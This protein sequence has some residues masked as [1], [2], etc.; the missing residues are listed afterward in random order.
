MQLLLEYLPIVAFFV[1]YKF[2]GGIYTATA[3]LMIS[4]PLLLAVLWLRAKKL[5]A[6]FAVSTVLVLAFGAA[7]L[8]LRDP[9]FIQW[10]PSIFMWVLAAAFLGSVFI[11]RQPL[12]QRFLQQAVGD[13]PMSRS[14]WLKLNSAWIL[15]ALAVGALNLVVAF[16]A[17]ESTWVNFKL[18]GL[19]VLT[20]VFLL[21]QFYWLHAKGKLGDKA[22]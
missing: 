3:V 6:M 22:G 11:G 8:L 13:A 16:N 19:P 2:F 17:P 9:V 4:M 7:T 12:V 15:F 10:K 1:A 14:E 5:P 20:F 21:G 18:F